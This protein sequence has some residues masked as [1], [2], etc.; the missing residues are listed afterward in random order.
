M[1]GTGVVT[2]GWEYVAAAYAVSGVI[3]AGYVASVVWRYRAERARREREAGR[4][5]S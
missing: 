5:P 3:L 2:G 4:G 1:S